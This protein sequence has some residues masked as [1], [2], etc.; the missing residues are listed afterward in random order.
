[1]VTYVVILDNTCKAIH[2]DNEYAEQNGRAY[3]SRINLLPAPTTLDAAALAWNR[4][5]AHPDC[6]KFPDKKL[7][8]HLRPLT[9]GSE[10]DTFIRANSTVN[11]ELARMEAV[12][13]T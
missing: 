11:V 1:M 6:P 9:R 5:A 10:Y 4:K 12:W 13:H 8:M 7:K 2:H 3:P